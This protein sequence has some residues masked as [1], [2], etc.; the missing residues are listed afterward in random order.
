[1][2][3][4]GFKYCPVEDERV[5]ASGAAITM[6]L[7]YNN[8]DADPVVVSELFTATFESNDF[9]EWFTRDHSLTESTSNIIFSCISYMLGTRFPEIKHMIIDTSTDNVRHSFLKRR[10][11]LLIHGAFPFGATKQPNTIIL[12]GYVGDNIIVHDPLGNAMSQYN[13]KYGLNVVYPVEFL[14]LW[15][16]DPHRLRAIRIIPG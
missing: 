15:V 9:L 3:I 4:D 13:S 12:A 1:M 11:P 14:K 6:L 16:G 5:S 7:R 8:V 10:I 2:L